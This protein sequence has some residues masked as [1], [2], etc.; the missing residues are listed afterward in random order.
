VEAGEV[1]YGP[2]IVEFEQVHLSNTP[3]VRGRICGVGIGRNNG[4]NARIGLIDVVREWR[5]GSI[6]TCNSK[7]LN[8]AG[9][10]R[11]CAKEDWKFHYPP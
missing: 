4:F 8:L 3:K 7:T 2:D 10:N 1:V 5:C 6:I 9:K 11:E